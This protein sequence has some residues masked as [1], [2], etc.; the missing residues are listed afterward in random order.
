MVGCLPSLNHGDHDNNTQ[1]NKTT[2]DY[3]FY[4]CMNN[5]SLPRACRPGSYNFLSLSP[6]EWVLYSGLLGVGLIHC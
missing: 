1:F 5:Y 6:G 3:F 2:Y 4:L